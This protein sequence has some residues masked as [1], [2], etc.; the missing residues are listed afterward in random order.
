MSALAYGYEKAYKEIKN[1]EKLC[2]SVNPEDLS[3]KFELKNI[4]LN[5]IRD[6]YITYFTDEEIETRIKIEKLMDEFN[7]LEPQYRYLIGFNNQYNLAYTIQGMYK[8]P[9]QKEHI[10]KPKKE[11]IKQ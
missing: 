5:E 10:T 2:T 3:E 8:V 9:K 4:V 7:E 1:L 6:K 11:L